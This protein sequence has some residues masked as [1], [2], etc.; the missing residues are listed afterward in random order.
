MAGFWFTE[1][2]VRFRRVSI[3]YA[4]Y[5]YCQNKDEKNAFKTL[6]NLKQAF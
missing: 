6:V 3:V 5:V 1:V 4:N 2:F